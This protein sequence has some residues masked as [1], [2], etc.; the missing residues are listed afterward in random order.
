MFIENIKQA[1]QQFYFS[2]TTKIKEFFDGGTEVAFLFLTQSPKVPLP[3]FSKNYFDVVEI[4]QRRW[5][6]D[7]E[8]RLANVDQTHLILASN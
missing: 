7:S 4:Y 2:G 5:L 1:G 8:Q 6:K 3:A